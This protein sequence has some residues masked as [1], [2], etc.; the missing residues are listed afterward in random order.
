MA[1][2]SSGFQKAMENTHQSGWYE[3]SSDPVMSNYAMP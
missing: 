1:G 2:V 3:Q